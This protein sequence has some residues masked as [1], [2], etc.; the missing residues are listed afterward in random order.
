MNNTCFII[1]PYGPK[2]DI[3]GKS[4]DF[5]KV[6]E[7]MIK[8]AVSSIEGLTCVRC[9]D[10]EQPGWI[11]ERMLKHIL[12]DRVAVVDTSTLNAN[13][14]YEL[15]VRHALRRSTTVLIQRKGSTRPFNIAGMATLD[16]ETTP[17]GLADGKEALARWI[18]NAVRDPNYS[19][20]LV[21]GVFPNLRV[22][23]RQKQLTEV[24]VIER[25]LTKAPAKRVGFVTGDRE[26]IKVGDIWVNSENTNMQ[27]DTYY[28]KSTSATIRYLGAR[29]SET[30]KIEEDI[31]G[32]ELKAKMG[33]TMEVDAGTVLVTGPGALERN[34]VR[35]IFHVAS[36]IGQPLE[37][38]RTVARIDQC[39]KNVLRSA[40][41]VRFKQE[42][43]TSILFPI[44][45]TGQGGGDLAD[46]TQV[47]LNAAVEHLESTDTHVCAVYF[48]VWGELD[49]EI[50]LG[51]ANN[52]RGLEKPAP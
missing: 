30:G 14:F 5:D 7:L 35:W 37:G 20:S 38:Y 26:D 50:C 29:R 47:C 12:E 21:F 48:Y 27:M 25:A 23:R 34:N 1:M 24:Q 6:Y 32:N 13:V 51:V 45:G 33:A 49:L 44:F 40:K 17:R 36:V 16:Y 4:I 18:A 39:V 28:G 31:I 10:I 52:L 8:Q 46:Q 2:K 3:D 43:G 15:G 42:G 41:D 19:D 22:E 11:Y 9:D